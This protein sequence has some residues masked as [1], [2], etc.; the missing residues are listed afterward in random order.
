MHT[1]IIL[2]HDVGLYLLVSSDEPEI[3]AGEIIDEVILQQLTNAKA[4][5]QET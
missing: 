2:N 5:I 3:S 4:G 1:H